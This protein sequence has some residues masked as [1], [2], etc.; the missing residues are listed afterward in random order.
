[1]K[2][3]IMPETIKQTRKVEIYC[4]S[5]ADGFKFFD[6]KNTLLFE[7]GDISSRMTPVLIFSDEQ[8]IGVKAKLYPG[9]Q[10][11]YTDFQFMVCKRL[12]V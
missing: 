10:A 5:T 12:G 11:V 3:F 4:S 9:C 1:M 8:I 6:D 7:V 2:D